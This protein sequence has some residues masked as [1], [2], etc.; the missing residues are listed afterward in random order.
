MKL[1]LLKIANFLSVGQPIQV[2]LESAGLV[3]IFGVNEDAN[4]A[5][6]GSGKST[7]MEAIVWCLFGET[8]R[9]L[10]GDDVVNL[11]E[12]ENCSVSL[13]VYDGPNCYRIERKR[14][15]AD[16]KRP[17]DLILECNGTDISAGIMT[18]TQALVESII[19]MNFSTFTQSV[20][21]TDK[22]QS[23]C[24]LTDSQQ[25]ALLESALGIEVL[26]RAKKEAKNR[27]DA[28]Q[29]SLQE[30]QTELR[31]LRT[32]LENTTANL[33]DIKE[34]YANHEAQTAE[35]LAKLEKALAG[36]ELALAATGNCR[37]ELDAAILNGDDLVTQIDEIN[38]ELR[39]LNAS[40]HSIKANAERHRT[41]IKLKFNEIDVSARHIKKD[42][43]AVSSLAGTVCVTCRQHVDPDNAEA[44]LAQWNA[45]LADHAQKR[46]ELNG[47][48]DMLDEA[49]T[50]DLAEVVA[51]VDVAYVT[52]NKL[53]TQLGKCRQ[54]IHRLQGELNKVAVLE[55]EIGSLKQTIYALSDDGNPFAG[56]PED[57]QEKVDELAAEVL[58]AE[59]EVAALAELVK[60]LTFWDVG[61]GN[62]GIKSL[63]LD[64]AIPFL[65]ERAQHYADH[66]SGGQIKIKFNTVT[67][68]K[69]GT[70]K[71]K[72]SVSVVNDVGSDQY[73]GNSSG[74]R[75]R[76][77]IAVSLALADLVGTRASKPLSLLAADEFFQG[78][79]EDGVESAFRLLNEVSKERGTVLVIT[80][81][82]ALQDKFENT[83]T[84]TKRNG[85]ST[86]IE[87]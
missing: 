51:A 3:G 10:K 57:L 72:F 18:D 28:C 5:S 54:E 34:R 2:D 37:E 38:G 52:K 55:S 81:D 21:L 64:S 44:Q 63:M 20:M 24:T 30:H 31:H 9:G 59:K 75:R 86:L 32:N 61:F 26:S 71:D 27:L 68:N 69:S 16:S 85:Y 58:A 83:W 60:Y 4:S 53:A 15:T 49:E 12:G 47:F 7:L 1:G 40:V 42:C 82:Q 36:K 73:K 48:M 50:N 35:K 87:T 56:M 46:E 22:T 6:N 62:A 65:E 39:D 25:K 84:M 45:V 43:D 66:M 33:N 67:E 78:L 77:D 74:E 17:N 23:F 76:A 13:F 80:H 41:Q 70:S 29:A 19:G 14:A 11:Q 8:T 79:D